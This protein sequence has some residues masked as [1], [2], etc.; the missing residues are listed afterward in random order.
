MKLLGISGTIIGSKTLVVTQK[1]LEEAK[2][3]HPDIEIELLDLRQ[4]KIDFCDGR[5]PSDYTGDTKKV[6]DIV[7]SA[8]M[9]VIG[10]P[11][12]HGSIP[13][14]LKNLLDLIPAD[15]F[16]H[17]VMGFIATG[18]NHQHYLMIENQLKPIAGYFQSYVVPGY[19]FAHKDD[20]ND[21]N[22]IESQEVLEKITQLANEICD[23]RQALK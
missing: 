8:D 17:K 21:N 1:V 3:Y 13:G 12:I 16:R 14:A 7:C 22:E 15:V 19:V 18:G 6:M 10:T 20:F 2:K 23:L 9:Y 11:I 4:Y 5:S